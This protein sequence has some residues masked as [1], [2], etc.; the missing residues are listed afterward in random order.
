LWSVVTKS[1]KKKKKKKTKDK[2]N[3]NDNGKRRLRDAH[4][5]SSHIMIL[6]LFS[7]QLR[8][9]RDKTLAMTSM[10]E[11]VTGLCSSR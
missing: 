6:F 11:I 1:T 3:G 5:I 10:V 9:P 4:F 8:L 7:M 2:G